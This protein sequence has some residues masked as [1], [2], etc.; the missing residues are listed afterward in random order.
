MKLATL[1]Y[2]RNENG[3]YLL[4]ERVK[5][6]NKGLLS[7][8][9]GKLDA[10][11]AESPI[12]CAVREAS[13]E[14][15]I[16]SANTDWRLLGIMTEK[17]FPHIGDIMVFLFEFKKKVNEVPPDFHEGKFRFIPES[18]IMTSNIPE[19]DKMFIWSSILKEKTG[20]VFFLNMDCTNY[21]EII[22]R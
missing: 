13:E 8:P 16:V 10:H 19:T 14:C 3:D 11:L 21:P 7:P 15:G 12:E 18:E 22:L 17:E 1:L 6:P 2:I 9:G 5:N 4:L 20:E